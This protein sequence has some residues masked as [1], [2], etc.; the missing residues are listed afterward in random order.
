MPDENLIKSEFPQDESLVYL[1]HAAVAPW[2]A[3]TA[4]AVEEFARENV[5]SGARN[6]PAWLAREAQLRRQCRDLINAPDAEDVALLKNT[7]EA[8]SVVADGLDWRDGDNV[9][10]SNEEFPSNRIP[11]QYQAGKGVTL[12]E[13]DLHADDPEA[14]LMA[15]CDGNTRVLAI[16]SVQYAS[17]LRLD[18]PRLGGF[19]RARDIV[20][21]ID[22]I[23]S[24]GAHA[25]DIESAQADC[26]MADA[27]KWMLGPEGIALFWCRPQ[28]RDRL[29]LHQFGW[30]MVR[31][32]G[33]FD[34]R[35]G[36]PADS[37]RRF[38]CG[39]AN[40]L[41]I[42]ALSA[43]LSLFAEAGMANVEK[44]VLDNV[45]YL[46]DKLAAMPGVELLTRGDPG[47]LA[48]ILVF[49]AAGRDSAELQAEL[50]RNNVVCAA[51]GGGVRFSPHFYTPREK[52]DKALEIVSASI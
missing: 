1:N 34:S 22:A 50:V 38:E 40:M 39:S 2:P 42:H 29:T 45:Q 17:G 27:H 25:F 14:A 10:I 19:C 20:F 49:R 13:V 32:A 31:D 8:L 51:R 33:N 15:A 24:L 26:V 43:S 3:R 28:L 47:R 36:T 18:L 5:R 16:S 46:M 44:R 35:D 9:V 41:G 23:Q 6:Y 7:S 4:Q 11:W 12:R 37:G 30:H 21:C 52:L 48:G